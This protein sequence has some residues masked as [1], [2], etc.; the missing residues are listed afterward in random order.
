MHL[1]KSKHKLCLHLH[2][3]S[4][5]ILEMILVF[6][7]VKSMFHIESKEYNSLQKDPKDIVQLQIYMNLPIITFSFG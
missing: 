3:R 2:I 4:M 7:I 5:L 1:Y 6:E